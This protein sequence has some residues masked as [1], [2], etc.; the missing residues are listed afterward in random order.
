MAV[1]KGLI[2]VKAPSRQQVSTVYKDFA[3]QVKAL[4]KD[5]DSASDVSVFNRRLKAHYGNITL[6]YD[7]DRS[8]WEW[9]KDGRATHTIA[10]EVHIFTARGHQGVKI[11]KVGSVELLKVTFFANGIQDDLIGL[12]E[13]DDIAQLIERGA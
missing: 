2:K 13:V 5:I 6:I 10:V 12:A 8:H 7:A 9:H 1:L 3:K 11:R 4:A